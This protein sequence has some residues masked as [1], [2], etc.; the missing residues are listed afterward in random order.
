MDGDEHSMSGQL[1]GI[2]ESEV[3]SKRVCPHGVS[4][5]PDREKRDSYD[6][7]DDVDDDDDWE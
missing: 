7:D 6:D 2:K 4:H 1:S 5:V 3:K